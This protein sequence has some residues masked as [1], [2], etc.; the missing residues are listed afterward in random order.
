MHHVIVTRVSVGVCALFAVCV[1]GFAWLAGEAATTP[2]P[3]AA[4]PPDGGP[5]TEAQAAAAFERYCGRC[6][7]VAEV[8]PDL[9]GVAPNAH[10]AELVRFLERHGDASP[11]ED[12]AILAWLATRQK[13][14]AP[15]PEPSAP[16]P[17]RR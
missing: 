5:A 2:R 9:G 16:P 7:S 3:E 10:L 8:T 14:G 13:G 12:V 15:A 1:L 4:S 17:V 11:A 6:H